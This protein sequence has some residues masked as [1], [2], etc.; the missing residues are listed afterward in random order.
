MANYSITRYQ[1]GLKDSVD[2]ALSALETQLETVDDSKT[3]RSVGITLTGRD[4]Q[5]AVGFVLYDT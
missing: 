3:I 4:R 1:T 2:A 5:Q